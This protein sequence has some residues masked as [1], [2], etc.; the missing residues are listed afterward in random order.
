MIDHLKLRSLSIKRNIR[1]CSLVNQP[2]TFKN[3][4]PSFA[5]TYTINTLM[6]YPGTP[7]TRQ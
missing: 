5:C 2:S 3:Q 1:D 6:H 4:N 7:S